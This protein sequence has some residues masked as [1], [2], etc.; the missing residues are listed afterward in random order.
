MVAKR[1]GISVE[2]LQAN[3][4][5]RRVLRDGWMIVRRA[6]CWE[7]PTDVYETEEGLVVQVEIAGICEDDID[8]TLNERTLVIQGV[9]VDAERKRS[10]HQMEIRYGEFR[11]EVYLPA[12]VDAERVEATYENGL[13]RICFPFPP[14]RQV[15]VVAQ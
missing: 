2:W 6:Q 3:P 14:A 12:A 9:R 7:P 10:Y 8:I 15:N 4:E 1:R 13:L 11:S 5:A